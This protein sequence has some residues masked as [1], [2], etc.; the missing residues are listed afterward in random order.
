[1]LKIVQIFEETGAEAE[2]SEEKNK[3]RNAPHRW[4]I[5]PSK[6]TKVKM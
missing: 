2:E 3:G 1:V 6:E 5:I 4:R